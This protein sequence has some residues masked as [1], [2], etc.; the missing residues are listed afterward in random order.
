MKQEKALLLLGSPKQKGTTAKM[1]A[2]AEERLK[3]G[4]KECKTICI[5][6]L[7]IGPCLGCG[8]CR[9]TGI[10][11][12]EDGLGALRS[13]FLSS[14]LIVLA[15]PTYFANIPGPV[16]NL[17]DRLSG[18]VIDEQAKAKLPRGQEYVLMT[19]CA[20]PPVLN[21]VSGQSRRALQ[22][23]NEFF[24]LARM[25]CKGKVAYAG[26]RPECDLPQAV[27]QKI[28]RILE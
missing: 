9:K 28:K 8:R 15:A 23:M 21:V 14:Q 20:T 6:D 24:K 3:E 18:V 2:Y 22:S 7:N 5:Y 4:Y 13:E 17:L 19:C 25:S 1:C 12:L 26:V 11:P 27:K 16:K 10:C